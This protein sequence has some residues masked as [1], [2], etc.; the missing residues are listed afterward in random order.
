MGHRFSYLL[1][2]RRGPG[3]TYHSYSGDGDGILV[4]VACLVGH[5][6]TDSGTRGLVEEEITDLRSSQCTAVQGASEEAAL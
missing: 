2:R 5:G 1:E 4:L 6:E 3:G